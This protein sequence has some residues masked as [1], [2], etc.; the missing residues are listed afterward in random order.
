MLYCYVNMKARLEDRNKAIELRRQGHSYKEIQ[1]LVRVSK[2]LLSMWLSD[3]KLSPD[4]EK[5]L[6]AKL[7][8]RKNRGKLN[9]KI[10]NHSRRLDRERRIAKE[11]EQMFKKWKNNPAFLMGVMLFWTQGAQ[12][13]PD[14][15]FMSKDTDM[16]FIMNAW[17]QNYLDVGKEHVKVRIFLPEGPQTHGITGFWAKNLGISEDLIKVSREKSRKIATKTDPFNKGCVRLTVFGVRYKRLM[18]IWQKLVIDSHGKALVS[19][20]I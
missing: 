11:G 20:K 3:L 16:I 2:G 13:S 10:L 6:H 8:E 18:S 9:S 5:R 1:T 19:H 14:F 17:I 4:E 7:Q 12:A 15:N